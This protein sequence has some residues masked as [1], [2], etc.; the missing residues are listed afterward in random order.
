MA[1]RKKDP[2]CLEV[3]VNHE[4]GRRGR[5]CVTAAFECLV[6]IVERQAERQSACSQD[7]IAATPKFG[8]PLVRRR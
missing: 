3:R 7:A 4:A 8:R 6:P 2:P 5:A 1:R